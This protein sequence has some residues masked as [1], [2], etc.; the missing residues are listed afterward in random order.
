M[1]LASLCYIRHSGKTLMLHRNKRPDDYHFGRWN[2]IGGKL[3][4]GESPEEAVRREVREESSLEIGELH[5]KGMITFPL[6]DGKD[7]WYV[8]VFTASLHSGEIRHPAEGELA[9]IPDSEIAALNLW[10]GDRLFLPWLTENRFFS[11]KL[12]YLGT[13]LVGHSVNFY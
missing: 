12:E 7:D 11:A 10:P 4:A 5:L 6:F 9:W 8:F 2:G 3:E 13:E 1:K